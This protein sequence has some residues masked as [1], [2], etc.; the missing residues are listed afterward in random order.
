MVFLNKIFMFFKGI[1]NHQKV[2]LGSVTEPEP[3]ERRLFAGAGG[4]NLKP[5]PSP[6]LKI[7]IKLYK[8]P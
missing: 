2:L 7:H 5:D 4:K 3:V 6:G 8:T 1:N